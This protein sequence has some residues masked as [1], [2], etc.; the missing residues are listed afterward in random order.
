MSDDTVRAALMPLKLEAAPLR[1]KI[2]T[3]LRRAIETG[4]L[5]PG[6]RLV[7]KDLC[8][9]L[10]VSRTSLREALRELQAEKLVVAV[11]RGLIVAEISDEDAANIYQVRAALEGLVAAQF[12][13]TANALDVEKLK[14]ALD[15]L[16]DAYRLKDFEKILDAKK[17][18]YDAICHG[19]RNAVV[20]DLL[21]N[22][23]N[24][25]RSTSREDDKRWMASL[26]ELKKLAGALLAR[27]PK[28]ARAAAIKHVDAAARTVLRKRDGKGSAS[29]DAATGGNKA[30]TS[31]AG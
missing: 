29:R 17:G 24:Q 1:R 10:N 11:P 31:G 25:L 18:F 2:L 5:K 9:E 7:E 4:E 8:Q 21:G 16:E 14:T 12:A 15:R 28:A 26:A 6:D 13:E 20:R 22:R 19:A 23:I 27:N 3:A 30:R